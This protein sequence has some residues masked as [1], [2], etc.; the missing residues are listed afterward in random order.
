LLIPESDR[1]GI[2]G[3]P[4]DN[5]RHIFIPPKRFPHGLDV[6]DNVAFLDQLLESPFV[7][8]PNI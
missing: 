2:D 3:T 1:K 7:I 6:D 5:K 8:K 4:Y